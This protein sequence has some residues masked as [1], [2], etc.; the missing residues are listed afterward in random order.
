MTR[1]KTDPG[2]RRIIVDYFFPNGGIND[3]I[4]KSSIFGRTIKQPTVQQAV[5]RIKELK[6]KVSLATIDLERAYRNFRVDLLDWPLT[7]IQ[8]HG[9]YYVDTGV[10]FGSGCCHYICKRLPNLSKGG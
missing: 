8:H 1:P 10:L 9:K 3:K 4:R 6:F 5:D 2:K 7:C